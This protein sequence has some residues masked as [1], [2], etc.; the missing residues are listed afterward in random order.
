M[1]EGGFAVLAFLAVFEG[2]DD[3]FVTEVDGLSGVGEFGLFITH[4]EH[5]E[6]YNTEYLLQRILMVV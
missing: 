1:V 3:G 6:K 2:F 4:I 5:N